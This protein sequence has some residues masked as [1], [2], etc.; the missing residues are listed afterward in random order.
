MGYEDGGRRD[1]RVELAAA[2]DEG[3]DQ[4]GAVADGVCTESY[5][6]VARRRERDPRGVSA[7]EEGKRWLEALAG[8]NRGRP[9]RLRRVEGQRRHKWA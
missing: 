3:A 5:G 4:E 2:R 9:E 8:R 7:A 6:L 1:D